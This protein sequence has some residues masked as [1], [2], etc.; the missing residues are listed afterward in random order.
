MALVMVAGF[1]SA[2]AALV[3]IAHESVQDNIPLPTLNRIYTGKMIVLDGKQVNPVNLSSGNEVRQ[4][5]LQQV[6]KQDDDK[7]VGY[8]IVRRSIGKGM[9]P[10]EFA[11]VA[12]IIDYVSK[13]PGAIGYIDS[14]TNLPN[15]VKVLLK[16]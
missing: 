4:A 1:S 7:Y 14:D 9:P 2:Q 15:S 5:F 16:K 6:L 3:V 12:E 10:K 8:W 13:T 11:T